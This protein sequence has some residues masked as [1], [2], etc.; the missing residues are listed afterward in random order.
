[1]GVPDDGSSCSYFSLL[2]HAVAS[3]AAN[4]FC[5]ESKFTGAG[6]TPDSVINAPLGVVGSASRREPVW[7]IEEKLQVLSPAYFFGIPPD[8]ASI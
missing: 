6:V 7:S 8:I 1:M 4:S 5:Q 2:L 3:L